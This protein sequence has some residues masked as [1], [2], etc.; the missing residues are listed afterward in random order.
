[1]LIGTH[2]ESVISLL[3]LV[4]VLCSYQI[5][6]FPNKGKKLYLHEV[7]YIFAVCNVELT[8]IFN[9]KLNIN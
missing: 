2:W 8:D 1:M 9:S 7:P 4:L 5:Y 3:L 6:Q